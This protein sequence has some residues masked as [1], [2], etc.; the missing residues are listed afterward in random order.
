MRKRK[1]DIEFIVGIPSYMEADSIP[2]VTRQV[3]EGLSRY[4][5]VLKTLIVNV[6]NNSEDD[7]KGAFLSTETKVPKHYITTPKGI[8]GKGNNFLNLFKYAAKHRNTLKGVVVVDADLLSIIPEWIKYMGDTILKGHDYALPYYSRHQFDGSITNHICCPLLYGLL[9]EDIRQP[10]GGEFGFSP[11]LMDYWLKKKWTKTTRQYG[12]DI[13]MTLNAILG[14]FR[15]CEVG[16]GAKIHK[17]SAPKLGPMFTQVVTTL[18]D[19]ILSNKENWLHKPVVKS[20]PKKRFGLEKLDPPQELKIDIR[21][22]KDQLRNAYFQRE[23]LLKKYLNEYDLMS[24]EAM[25]EQDHYNIDILMW[26]QVVYQLFYIY[27]TGSS[28]VKK[29]I[30]EALKP[31]YFGRSVTFNYLT[32]RY[33]VKYAEEHIRGQAKAFASQKPYLQ[34][35]YLNESIKRG[36]K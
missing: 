33:D 36:K 5:S 15:I 28:R 12:I 10:I 34:G 9:G 30:V 22:L 6:D 24:L 3:D 13:F 35:L 18:F 4:Y 1:D 32:W 2:F 17:A 20:S 27:D 7:T 23:E 21:A 14:N 31:L 25:F 16:L 11:D 26:T 8:R 19:F 29:D